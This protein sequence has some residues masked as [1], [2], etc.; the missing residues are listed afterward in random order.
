MLLVCVC[1]RPSLTQTLQGSWYSLLSAH[2]T[3][4]LFTVVIGTTRQSY[5]AFCFHMI[6][7]NTISVVLVSGDSL[8]VFVKTDKHGS[9]FM[10][11]VRWHEP[12]AVLLCPPCG[13]LV[14]PRDHEV[15]WTTGDLTHCTR[16]VLFPQTIQCLAIPYV[17][18]CSIEEGVSYIH[19]G[20]PRVVL[21]ILHC[22][23]VVCSSPCV[24]IPAPC[25]ESIVDQLCPLHCGAGGPPPADV[26]QSSSIETGCT[27]WTRRTGW[28]L[29]SLTARFPIS[30]VPPI[31]AWSTWDTCRA[32]GDS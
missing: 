1:T 17:I 19:C 4:E 6:H 8:R 22:T 2:H 25:C 27:S 11:M 10:A 28:S 26:G 30:A 20:G 21:C 14:C 7:E 12:P 9:S 29:R 24:A 23:D 3:G 31:G 32:G 16:N 15:L 13:T 5:S 18:L